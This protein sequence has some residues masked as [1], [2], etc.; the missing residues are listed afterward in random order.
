MENSKECLEKLFKNSY[1]QQKNFMNDFYVKLK[2]N[3]NIDYFKSNS[4]NLIYFLNTFKIPFAIL[5]LKKEFY[6]FSIQCFYENI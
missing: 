3:N 2:S 6:E 5:F 1:E 4:E